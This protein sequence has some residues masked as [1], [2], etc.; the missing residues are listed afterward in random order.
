MA[1]YCTFVYVGCTE[2]AVRLRGGTNTGEGR[3]EVCRSN[4]WGTVCDDLWGNTDAN[5]SLQT[6]GLLQ[7]Q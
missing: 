6:T 4:A 5:G 1:P 2:G 3:V 7:I